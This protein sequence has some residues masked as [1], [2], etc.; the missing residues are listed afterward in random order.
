MHKTQ[1]CG[2]ATQ[3][4]GPQEQERNLEYSNSNIFILWFQKPEAEKGEAT[5]PGRII[6][7]ER[8]SM[9]VKSGL[10]QDEDPVS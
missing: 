9:D 5:H 8:K 2:L 10:W 4:A 1:L 7:L 6:P 3:M